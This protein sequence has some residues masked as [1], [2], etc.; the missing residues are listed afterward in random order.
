MKWI[1]LCAVVLWSGMAA[2][3]AADTPLSIENPW[4]RASA[5]RAAGAF[6]TI[7]NHGDG[8]DTLVAVQSKVAKDVQLHTT[9][10]EGEV[11]KMRPVNGL[12]VPGHGE[13][14]LQPGGNHIMLMGLSVPLKEGD[15]L[16][17]TLVFA[18]AGKVDVMIPVQKA[19]ASGPM[20]GH[21]HGHMM[22]EHQ[23]AP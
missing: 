1:V 3:S 22:M 20:A 12:A 21:D 14:K 5:G 2:V 8:D 11:M 15:I 13:V 6:L 17:L 9:V 4:A 10:K 18:K 16:P 7:Q 19:G 23:N